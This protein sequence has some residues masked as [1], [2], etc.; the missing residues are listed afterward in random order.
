M[1]KAVRSVFDAAYVALAVE[2]KWKGN[3]NSSWYY[4]IVL[5]P[6]AQKGKWI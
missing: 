5:V 2:Y 6:E 3:S 1:N 4:F